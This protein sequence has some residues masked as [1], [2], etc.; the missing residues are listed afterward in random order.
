MTATSLNGGTPLC[1]TFP[2]GSASAHG[3]NDN[4]NSGNA[5]VADSASVPNGS[6]TLCATF[7]NDNASAYGH[8]DNGNSSNDLHQLTLLSV[9]V[10][11]VHYTPPLLMAALQLEFVRP[12]RLM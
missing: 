5:T 1:A 6:S 4:G 12:L 10:V 9:Q 7:L 3:H 11:A 8:N 2:N